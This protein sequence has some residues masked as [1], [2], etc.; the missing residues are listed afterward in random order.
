[1]RGGPELVRLVLLERDMFEYSTCVRVDL[2]NLIAALRRGPPLHQK[3]TSLLD[4]GDDA[5]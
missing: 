2:R 1:M 4:D 5:Q 3:A